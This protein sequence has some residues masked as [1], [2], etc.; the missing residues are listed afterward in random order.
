M[1]LQ[2]IVGS[3]G[4]GKS[5]YLYQNV[6]EEAIKNPKKNYLVVVPEQFTMHTQQQLVQMHPAHSIMNI[7]ILSFE[8]MAYRVF[9][10][11][12]TDT[13]EVL[14]ETGKHLL[15]R[16]ISQEKKDSLEVL[17]KNVK[18]PGYITQ[19]KSLISEF[20]QYDIS[21]ETVEEMVEHP[22]MSKAFKK[23]TGDILILYR[24]Y[25]N[26]LEGSYI[27]GEEV[28]Q[29]LMDV[30]EQSEILRGACVV[31]DGFTGFTPIQNQFLQILLTLAEK[32][33]V[34]VTCDPSEPLFEK[35]REE[36]LFAMSK[37]M[38]FRL[39]KMAQSVGVELE[40]TV[41]IASEGRGRF[42]QGGYLSHL[43]KNIFRPGANAYEPEDKVQDEIEM[44]SLANPRQ[45]LSYVACDI[46]N[47]VRDKGLRYRDFAVVCADMES[48]AHLVDGI[49]QK[50]HIPYFLDLKS[51]V[52]FQPFVESIKG[53]FMVVEE[54]YS[55][56]GVLRLLRTGMTDLS[57]EE[58]DLLENY[59]LAANIRGKSAYS[60]PFLFM[61]MGY[62]G[63]DMVRINEI[64]EKF[65]A[66]IHS[67][68]DAFP[69]KRGTARDI[70]VA[71]YQ[72]ICHYDMEAKLQRK[73]EEYE[74][75][76]QEAKAKEYDQIYGVVM[77]LLDKLVSILG[78]EEM[79]LDEYRELLSTG[80]ES[81]GIGVIP[82]E[83]DV[84]MIGDMERSRLSDVKV[85]YLVGVRDGAIPQNASG[86][87]ILSQMER[88]QLKDADFELAPSDREK[89]FMQRFYLYLVM[90]KPSDKLVVTYGRMDG[91]G[92]AT[93]RSYLLGV[94][95]HLFPTLKVKVLEHLPLQWQMM[96]PEMGEDFLVNGLRE[97]AE[98]GVKSGELE[99]F[100]WW[101][102]KHRSEN[103]NRWLKAAYFE[104]NKELLSPD[105]ISSVFAEHMTESV[106]RL[107][108]YAKCA[109]AY[110]LRYGLE[111]LPRQEHSF[112]QMDM[113]NLYH[114]ALE[115]YSVE[116]QK[117]KDVNWYTI[118]EEQMGAL[119]KEAILHSYQTITKT[120]VFSQA[121]DA[122]VLHRMEITLQ[123]TIWAL[124]EQV[125][126]GSFVPTDFEV[127][128]TEVGDLKSMNIQLD[129]MHTMKL[130]GK[131]DR[132]DLCKD[133]NKVYVKIVDY[134]SG[135]KDLDFN[136]LYNGLQ[137]Q[138][139]L[140]LNATMEGL[141]KKY[142][143][144]EIEPGAMFYYHIHRPLVGMDTVEKSSR[145]DAILKSLKMKGV[146]NRDPQIVEAM[147]HGLSGKS[148]VIPVGVKKDGSLDAT[149]SVVSKEDFSLMEQY[150]DMLL[151]K[152]GHA[153]LRGE[154][155]CNPYKMG[156]ENGCEYCDYQGI[157][158][159]DVKIPGYEYRA[160][161]DG[162]ERE[163]AL[164][165]MEQEL[166][167]Y[168][169]KNREK[170][171]KTN[172]ELDQ[173]TETG[174]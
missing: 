169:G 71:L 15:L 32:V 94:L 127:D 95:E 156:A 27:T 170:G 116:L 102:K 29:K 117:R 48:Y 125:R 22:A 87:G 158:G 55:Y 69:S 26:R 159:F 65:M 86:G 128:F 8:R 131:I 3:A 163:E 51:Q 133:D 157:C 83:N 121:R 174:H 150:V 120:Q 40:E 164:S 132:I 77:G 30:A 63:D 18:K 90:T 143:D 64:R 70:S 54:N 1:S 161:K 134:K 85:L 11:L 76:H 140:Y 16:K 123:Q 33:V 2:F 91:S 34:T 9:D 23:K 122:Y 12:G 103:L 112:E 20:M 172:A 62:T 19:I 46:E 82:P 97:Y 37:E 58:I 109:Y 113:G 106:S 149:S 136:Q 60:N 88:Q 130:R 98:S 114:T 73:K 66:P 168:H 107:E 53:L 129:E 166:A 152:T 160:C 17:S 10:E 162:M 44:V 14:E 151:E 4:S 57:V 68:S 147:D 144:R 135:Q 31:F 28:L 138:L 35:P 153:I 146:L 154:I 96:T 99:E 111:L 21:P 100:L 104:H 49:F 137:V 141:K 36:E 108:Q 67:F 93:R 5:T 74:A 25:K 101:E 89:A 126:R 42:C 81:L 148:N 80:F 84:V 47:Q 72:W 105:S 92:K 13:L 6:I 139:V 165:Q 171:G 38:V 110:F 142:P 79:T 119:L 45:E 7:D 145:E 24:E 173:G 41:Y 61:P 52:L 118:S 167:I 124:T 75:S 39:S 43:E 59:I 50:L 115:Y 56:Q 155:D 78:Q